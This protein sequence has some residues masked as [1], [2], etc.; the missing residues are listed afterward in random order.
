MN[1]ENNLFLNSEE[2][3]NLGT[4]HINNRMIDYYPVDQDFNKSNAF[5]GG[6][7]SG[8]QGKLIEISELQR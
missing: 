3:Q 1:Y 7:R 5:V 2:F 8:G 4:M 6:K